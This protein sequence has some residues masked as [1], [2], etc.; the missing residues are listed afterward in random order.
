MSQTDVSGPVSM[1]LRMLCWLEC[2][3]YTLYRLVRGALD[4]GHAPAKV[5]K[6][7]VRLF[8]LG[9]ITE[10]LGQPCPGIL[11]QQPGLASWAQGTG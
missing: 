9:M 3:S 10:E 2:G 6:I 11:E 1:L 8:W 4:Q 5:I 7:A